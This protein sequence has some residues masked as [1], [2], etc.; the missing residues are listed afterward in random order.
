MYLGN[1]SCCGNC[2]ASIAVAERLIL[3]RQGCQA[4]AFHVA[5]RG[6]PGDSEKLVGIGI[7][8]FVPKK[9]PYSVYQL[10]QDACL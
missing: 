8:F 4:G 6:T 10:V 2:E 3:P 9:S 7:W 1:V 5:V